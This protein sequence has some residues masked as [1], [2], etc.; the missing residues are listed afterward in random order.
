MIA[1]AQRTAPH[2]EFVSVSSTARLI[3]AHP[4]TIRNM[5]KDGRLASVRIG[6]MIR[7]PMSEIERLK[8]EA[9][10]AAP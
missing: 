7:I 3:D 8:G 10:R 5:L 2:R 9:R 6:D 1:T 4:Q